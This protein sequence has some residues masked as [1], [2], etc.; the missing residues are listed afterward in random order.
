MFRPGRGHDQSRIR[1]PR[2]TLAPG[3]KDLQAIYEQAQA[4]RGREVELT[5]Q[6]PHA[7]K[8]YSIHVKFD[9]VTPQPLW[10]IWENSGKEAKLVW[11]FETADVNMIYDVVAM[12]DVSH[13][14]GP[15]T[16]E[17]TQPGGYVGVSGSYPA[18]VSPNLGSAISGTY[19][20]GGAQ[21]PAAAPAANMNTGQFNRQGQQAPIQPSFQLP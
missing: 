12:L 21:N 9:R 5:W 3:I 13:S 20:A 18:T 15:K 1:M 17:L 19:S 8:S 4:N 11:R 2:Q 16:Q 14:A 7:A 6:V 10:N